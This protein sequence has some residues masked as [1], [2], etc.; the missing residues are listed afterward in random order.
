[1]TQ[2]HHRT[3]ALLFRL[4]SFVFVVAACA[5]SPWLVSRFD[6]SPPL[7]PSTAQ[8]LSVS[9]ATLFWIGLAVVICAELVSPAVL[10]RFLSRLFD[11]PIATKLLT[12]FL[13]ICVPLTIMELGLRPFTVAHVQKKTT[14][15]FISD[16]QLGWRMRPHTTAPWGGV[17]VTTN[18]K[19]LYGPEVSYAR[20]PSTPRLLFL[21]DSVT[22]GHRL[23]RYSQGYPFRIE[24]LLEDALQKDV[25]TVNAGVGGYSPWQYRIFLEREGLKY[26]PDMI[27]V[28]FVLN[29]VT[30]KFELRQFGGTGQGFQLRS[31]YSSVIDRF[32]H[33]S[34]LCTVVRRLNA[35]LHFGA[36]VHKGAV[37]HEVASV[38][39]LARSPE[40][41]R[42]R[43]AWSITIGNLAKLAEVCAKHDIPLAIVLFP[44]A[45]QLEDAK[46]LAAPQHTLVSWCAAERIP[47]LDL[48]PLMADYLRSGQKSP[49]SLFI[50]HDHLTA[51]GC[52]VAA[53]FVVMWLR[54]QETLWASLAAT[55][56]AG[57][58]DSGRP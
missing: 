58:A 11:R 42:V 43:Y 54:T 6:P 2:E 51:H 41:S 35:R 21:G 16:P 38:E 22:F 36:D 46:T 29:D 7:E 50:D 45:F 49:A 40:S 15:L 39:D 56:P 14:N 57:D 37:A 3:A 48:L 19:G 1:M 8:A 4:A 12:S 44:F 27:I 26:R 17:Q 52:E 31:S 30:E 28:G 55:R 53:R 10:S 24:A 18:G 9:R 34:A 5:C 25:E 23:P 20:T 47:C 13:V 33:N 32:R